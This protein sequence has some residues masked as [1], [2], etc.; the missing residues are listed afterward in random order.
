MPRRPPDFPGSEL[1]E[2]VLELATESGDAADDLIQAIRS[3]GTRT[4]HGWDEKSASY[5]KR[6][7]G[8]GRSGKLTGRSLTPA[9]TRSYW[10]RGGDLRGGRGHV[11]KPKGAA[12]KSATDRESVGMGDAGTYAELQRWRR[13]SPARGGPPPWIPSSE[14]ELGTDVAAILSQI[15]VP[16]SR[17][18]AVE[19]TFLPTGGAIMTVFPEHGYPRVVILP[20]AQAVSEVGRLLRAPTSLATSNA[21]RKRLERQW[22]RKAGDGIVVET[23]HY[24]KRR[25]AA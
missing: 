23:V 15:D 18:R 5:R 8:A 22:K 9:E 17:W 20:D 10:E 25:S 12:P 6:L 13:R 14:N 4:R 7:E 1:S 21:E 16:P 2:E 11:P 24:R 3:V 19:F